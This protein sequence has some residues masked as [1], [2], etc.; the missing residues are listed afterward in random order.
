MRR[1]FLEKETIVGSQCFWQ[2][3]LGSLPE[4]GP[5]FL[6]IRYQNVDP[7]PSGEC[8]CRH[9]RLLSRVERRHEMR[10]DENEGVEPNPPS[11]PT[12]P[13]KDPNPMP[14]K[15][16]SL[17]PPFSSFPSP[18][19]LISCLLSTRDNNLMCLQLQI[20][21][22]LFHLKLKNHENSYIPIFFDPFSN[23]YESRFMP[24]LSL[25]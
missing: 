20:Q 7:V 11:S 23:L 17:P 4:K 19:C 21:T 24:R 1:K 25:Y 5:E 16:L 6:N 10:H 3:L 22:H 9:I 13:P 15:P 8:S 12:F 18:L 2:F 14:P